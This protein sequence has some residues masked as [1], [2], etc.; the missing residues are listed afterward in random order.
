VPLDR[1]EFTA[2]VFDLD[3]VLADSNDAVER[4]LRYWADRHGIDFQRVLEVHHGRPTV[5]TIALLAPH[6]DPVEEALIIEEAAAD[7]LDGVRAFP[8]ATGLIGSL[9][10][11]RW[12]IATS[13]TRRIATNRIAHIGLA[14][15][16]VLVTANEIRRGKPAPDPYLLAAERLGVDPRNCVIVE[17][18]PAGIESGKAAGATVIAVASTLPAAM[19]RRA[20]LVV[21]RLADLAV[22]AAEGSLRLRYTGTAQI[23]DG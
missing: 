19:L 7:D 20:D 23:P 3:G 12:A 14:M 18:A 6:L 2:I 8:G 17:D 13:G 11:G 1:L 16:D 5:E 9:P 22:D 4:H 10:V 21:D 15:P